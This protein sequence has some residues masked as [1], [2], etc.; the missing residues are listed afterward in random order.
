M[1]ARIRGVLVASALVVAALPSFAAAQTRCEAQ[2]HD[3]KVAGTIIGG[4]LG[5]LAGNAIGR[6]GGRTGG[7]II[8]G[9]VGA[10][11]GNNLART[12]CPDGYA[13]VQ[14][15]N[16]VAPPVY[17]ASAPV[18]PPQYDSAGFWRQA[19]QGIR[20]RLDWMQARIDRARDERTLEPR[21]VNYAEH[22]L[23]D[24]RRMIEDLRARD[25]GRLN[26]ADRGY[27]QGRLDHLGQN[28]RWMRE[29]G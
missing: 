24:I 9:V 11:V 26:E 6:G 23:G 29:N 22:E 21:Q 13:E 4:V 18:P 2:A 17:E 20:E 19:P 12:H 7:T 8:G 15:P 27:I 28:L 16:Y 3:K 10:G 25:G 1:T 5:A 14:D